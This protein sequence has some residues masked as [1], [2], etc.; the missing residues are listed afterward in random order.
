MG[1]FR[2][3]R[4][5]IARNRVSFVGSEV[6]CMTCL[7]VCLSLCVCALRWA[8][9]VAY[10]CGADIPRVESDT[11]ISILDVCGGHAQEYHLHEGLRCL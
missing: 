3:V 6:T 1:V 8:Q 2:C 9:I 5:C 4:A 10:K 11:L 7:I